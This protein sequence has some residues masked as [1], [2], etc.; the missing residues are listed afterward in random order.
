MQGEPVRSTAVFPPVRDYHEFHLGDTWSPP[1][2]DL[3]HEGGPERLAGY[4]DTKMIQ[5]SETGGR[6]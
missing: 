5:F 4:L 3:G 6:L 1:R 2:G